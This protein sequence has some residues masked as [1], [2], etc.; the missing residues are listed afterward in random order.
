MSLKYYDL[1]VI[2][3]AD[4]D[5]TLRIATSSFVLNVVGTGKHLALQAS[6]NFSIVNCLHHIKNVEK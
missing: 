4:P 1:I 3:T 5:G 6:W 2:N